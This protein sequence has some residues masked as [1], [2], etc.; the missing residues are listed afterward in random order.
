MKRI[1]RK[2]KP[3]RKKDARTFEVL[4]GDCLNVLRTLPDN[5]IDAVVTDPHYG[6]EFMG[7]E[8]DK[9][10]KSPSGF[11]SWC[12]Q[13]AAE[14]LRVLKPGG[15]LLAFGGTRTFH[16]L[17]C[18]IE[19]AGFE[20]RD[21]ILDLTGRDSAGLAWMYGSGFPKSRDV[22]KDIDRTAGVVR[23]NKFGG[24][25]GRV[26]GPT[27]NKKCDVCGKWLVSGSP[28]RCPRPQDQP[29]T[30][31]ARQWQGWGTAMKPGWEPI[32]CARKPLTGTVASNVEQWGTGALNI[33]GCR[34][35][36][37]V[38]SVPQ[39]DFRQVNGVVT[40]L[41]AH[42]RNGEMS[43]AHGGRWP[44][45]VVLGEEASIELDRQ[46]SD[47]SRFFP[48]FKYQAKA[49]K[50]ERSE[51]LDGKNTHPTVKPLALIQFL[52]RLV[53]PPGGVV[54][55]PFTGSGTTGVACVREGFGFLGIEKDVGYVGI[56]RKRIDHAQRTKRNDG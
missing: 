10:R 37:D 38:P 26:I 13:W 40:R 43:V 21:A 4:L 8:W 27:G 47:A 46:G 49:G 24:A 36:G 41:D 15:H 6:L 29:V 19:D 16:R 55:D 20:I 52:V 48:V 28:C 42:A 53:T 54:L 22:S 25:I 9:F 44:P 17:A 50:K 31:A 14:C 51:G 5:S 1:L 12:E 2:K 33:N 18:G 56:A 11:Q 3:I 23:E 32:V 39:P 35:A 7:N 30:N 45:N 34:V